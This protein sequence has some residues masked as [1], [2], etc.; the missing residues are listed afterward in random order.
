MNEKIF[1]PHG[2]EYIRA[3]IEEAVRDGSRTATV[4]GNFEI[5]S[6]IRIP[7]DFTL[8]LS[9]CHLRLADGAYTNIF[10][11][12]HH[13]TALGRTQEGVDRNISVIGEG[14]AVLDGGE[15]NG[16]S[17][18]TQ[19]KDGRPPIWKNNFILFTN[20]E[21]FRIEGLSCRN[22]RWWSL[23]FIYCRSG[24]IGN[25]DFC[26][27][28]TAIDQEG[29]VYHGLKRERYEEVLVKNADGIDLRVGCHDIVIENISGFTE[30]DT[31]ALTGLNGDM[32]RHFA[33]DGLPS[34]IS[35]VSIRDVRSSAFCTIVRL[36][37]QGGVR[38]HD[39]S[40]EDIYDTADE[41][42]YF[43]LGLYAVRIGDVRL[44]GERHAT[45][46]ETYNISIK[47]VSGCNGYAVSLAGDMQ[48]IS[49]SGIECRGECK[50][51]LDER[52][53]AE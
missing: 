25:I 43:D 16:L 3:L 4:S 42:G 49:M 6:V 28:D 22:Q 29:R 18:R 47:N 8:V 53:R 45:K 51:L 36:L 34:D 10:V 1:M 21:G 32:E 38:L 11:N 26:A 5:D 35:H 27:N 13:D 50:P 9:D 41:N 14:C 12:E 39:I 15:Y 7:S 24:Y 20:V 33:V 31:I 30:D 52:V 46:E 40:I 23:N 48:G 37:N 17:E 19:C 44:Y 2:S